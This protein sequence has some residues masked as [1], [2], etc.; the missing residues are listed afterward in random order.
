[1]VRDCIWLNLNQ[2]HRYF[3]W[4]KKANNAETYIDINQIDLWGNADDALI[5]LHTFYFSVLD[6]LFFFASMKHECFIY[7]DLEMKQMY[8]FKVF[9]KD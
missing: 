5:A 3:C 8:L 7:L 2:F 9:T 6:I 4:T 1:M